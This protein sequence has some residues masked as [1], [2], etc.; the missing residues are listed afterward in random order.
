MTAS[1]NSQHFSDICDGVWRDRTAVVRGRGFLT[2]EAALV[3]AVY[4]RLCK[5][6]VKPT[7]RGDRDSIETIASYQSI[8]KTVLELSAHPPFD[9]APFLSELVDRYRT[10]THSLEGKPTK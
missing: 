9:G 1:I 2:A 4:W 5:A 3:R 7:D 10:E 8:V 6:G